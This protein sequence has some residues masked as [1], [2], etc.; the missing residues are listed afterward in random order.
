MGLELDRATLS[1]DLARCLRE[2]LFSQVKGS[3]ITWVGSGLTE[4]YAGPRATTSR[5]M[6]TQEGIT[7]Y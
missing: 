4:G 2:I 5:E 7:V 3:N 1:S 6:G